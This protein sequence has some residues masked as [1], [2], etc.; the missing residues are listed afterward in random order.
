MNEIL[1]TALVAIL[2]ALAFP[3]RWHRENKRAKRIHD[4]WKMG[5]VPF[6]K[7]HERRGK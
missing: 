4:R 5:N 3:Y 2:I 6:G 1:I 7:W